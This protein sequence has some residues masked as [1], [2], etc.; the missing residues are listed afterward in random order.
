VEL[1]EKEVERIKAEEKVRF[2][3]KRQLWRDSMGGHGGWGGYGYGCGWSSRKGFWKGFLLGILATWLIGALIHHH[4]GWGECPYG[5]GM[6]PSCHHSWG[7][8]YEG[9]EQPE[10]PAPEPKK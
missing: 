9:P 1:P 7:Q 2:E 6:G 4:R 5:Y 3:V 10:A 8:Q